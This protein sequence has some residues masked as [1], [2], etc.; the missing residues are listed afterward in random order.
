MLID[1]IFSVDMSGIELTTTKAQAAVSIREKVKVKEIPQAMGRMYGEL[2]TIMGKVQMVG[3]PFA[4]YHSWSNEEVDVECGFPIAGEFKPQGKFKAFTLPSVK[5]VVTMHVGP[6][7]K[8]MESYTK[9]EQWT[10][11]NGH[12]PADYMWEIYLNEPGKVP[13]EQL[14]T[15]LIWPIK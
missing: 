1:D 6:Y 9:M 15:Q 11:T 8:L 2:A 4:Y 10:R 5:A 7:D 13:P 14:M 3:P 12:T